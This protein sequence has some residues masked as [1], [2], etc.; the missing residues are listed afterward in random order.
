M[1][2]IP[3]RTIKNRFRSEINAIFFRKSHYFF[4]SLFAPKKQWDWV[5]EMGKRK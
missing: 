1:A 5:V 4:L 3:L 2:F